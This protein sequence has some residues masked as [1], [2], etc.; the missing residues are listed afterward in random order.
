MVTAVC[1]RVW[2]IWIT[3]QDQGVDHAV[4]DEE[5]AAERAENRGTPQAV[6]GAVFVPAPMEAESLPRCARC[7]AFLRARRDMRDAATRLIPLRARQPVFRGMLHRARH[8]GGSSD[9][10]RRR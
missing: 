2:F 4:T 3:A 1:G 5:L 7:V 8:G 9:V 10:G 6:C